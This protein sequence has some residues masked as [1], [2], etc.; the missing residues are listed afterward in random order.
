MARLLSSTQVMQLVDEGKIDLDVP[1]S[2]CVPDLP[3][4][5]QAIPLRDFLDHSSDIGEYYERAGN[6]WVSKGYTGLAPDLAAALKVAGA[7]PMQFAAGSRVQY[8][9]PT[10]WC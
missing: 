8:T 2:R 6:R 9:R 4:A 1:A 3:K 10:I 7:A 5:W